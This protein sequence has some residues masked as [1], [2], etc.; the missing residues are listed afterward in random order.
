MKFPHIAH[1]PR[2]HA[3]R[4]LVIILG[5]IFL[6]EALWAYKLIG[7]RDMISGGLIITAWSRDLLTACI[8]RL[9]L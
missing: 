1:M 9:K 4:L 5:S 7:H 3:V 2:V 6:I 8:E